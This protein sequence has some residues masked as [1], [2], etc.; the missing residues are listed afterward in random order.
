MVKN[1]LRFDFELPSGQSK[2][3]NMTGYKV[4][5]NCSFGA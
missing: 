3:E 2:E 1:E 4:P 5:D